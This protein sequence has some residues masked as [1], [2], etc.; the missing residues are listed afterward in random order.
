MVNFEWYR[1]FK[2]IYQSGTL[3]G[4]AQELLISQP[5]VSQHLSAL[6]NYIGHPLFE[7]KPRQ[8]VPTSYGK[9]FYTQIIEAVDKLEKVEGDFSRTCVKRCMTVINMGAPKEFYDAILAPRIGK[10]DDANI[11]MEFGLTKD[12]VQKLLKGDLNFVVST[13]ILEEK[14]IVC[15]PVLF[16]KFVLVGSPAIDTTAFKK[17]IRNGDLE[18]IENW[19]LEQNWF[20]YS[21][22]LIAIR[23]FWLHNFKK[24]PGLRPRFIVP[25]FNSILKSLSYVDGVTIASDYLVKDLL[26]RKELKEIWCGNEPT[27]N[28][29]YLAYDKTKATATNIKMVRGLFKD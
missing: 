15:E 25:D 9:L 10:T 14:N 28:T 21:S 4:A 8:M 3:T 13:G 27:T 22:D 7:R 26:Q 16:E 24:R 18:N 17:Y 29:I 23:R 12:L 11:V 1:T 2:A 20:A 5:N 6:E 19:M